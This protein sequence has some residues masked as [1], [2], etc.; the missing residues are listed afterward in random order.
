MNN[1]SEKSTS[2]AQQKLFGMVHAA[3][4]GEKPTSA[5]VAKLAKSMPSSEVDKFASTKHKGLPK[6]VKENKDG[7]VTELYA[8]HKAV[9]ECTQDSMVVAFNPINGLVPQGSQADHIHGVYSDIDVANQIA[10]KLY[11]ECQKGVAMLEEKKGMTTEKI[12]KSIDKLEKKRKEH[13]NMAKED[14]K[15]ASAHKEHIA[16]LATKID[17]LM[18]KLE[19]IEK[20][21]KEKTKQE[22]EA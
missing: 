6:K 20:S 8:V 15:N 22:E 18:V 10:E 1:I 9:P 17:D 3:Q 14:P 7:C 11:N 16:K 4:S 19:K 5:K 13:I 2:Q 12:K 21:K